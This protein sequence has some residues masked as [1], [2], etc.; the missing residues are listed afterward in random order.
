MHLCITLH[1]HSGSSIP[2]ALQELEKSKNPQHNPHPRTSARVLAY[3]V[4]FEAWTMIG[5]SSSPCMYWTRVDT[6]L[7]EQLDENAFAD[8][9]EQ[10]R[11]TL[12]IVAAAECGFELADDIVQHSAIVA[13][14]H[15]HQFTPGTNFKAWASTIVRGVAR[16][17]RRSE[18]RRVNRRLKL[19]RNRSTKHDAMSESKPIARISPSTKGPE[20]HLPPEFD[21]NLREALDTLSVQQRTCLLLR[22]LLD[23]TYTEIGEILDIPPAT[24]RSHVFRARANLLDIFHTTQS[25]EIE[26]GAAHD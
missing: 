1:N 23:H 24:A 5:L 18:Q 17:Q 13:L 14:K 21:A 26:K 8:L 12:R 11:S 16:N 25:T 20:V 15:L 22:S 19:I 10:S 4:T 9:F 3:P 7:K 2:T 6:D